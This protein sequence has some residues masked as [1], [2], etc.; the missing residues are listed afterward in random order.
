[1]TTPRRR[2]EQDPASTEVSEV[3][4]G[5]LRAQ[6]P[7][8]FTGLGHVNCYVLP[9]D[10]GATIVDP[11]MPGKSTMTALQARLDSI[12]IP[13]RRVHTVIVTHAHPDHYGGAGWVRQESGADIV[14]HQL[15]HTIIDRHDPPDLDVEDA[16]ALV[17]DG[18][19]HSR[20]SWW[21]PPPWGGKHPMPLSRRLL[22]AAAR[23]FPRFAKTPTPTRRITDG[24]TMQLAGRDW[25]VM[26][27]PGHTDDHVCFYDPTEGVLLSGDHVLPTITPHIGG[28]VRNADPLQSFFESLTKVAALGDQVHTVLPA[29]GHPFDDLAGRA[30]S[31]AE[32]H[33]G[34]L[35]VA[36][37]AIAGE[38]SATVGA[39]S[40]HLFSERAQGPMADSETYA[41]LEHLRRAGR[42]RRTEADDGFRYSLVAT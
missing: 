7:I 8:E 32:H 6:L 19:H 25:F 9:D 33:R 26:H 42:V 18:E 40:H 5:V 22:V 1:M 13:L 30:A 12:G 39:V 10:R 38:G 29:H 20:D 34:R 23:R 21:K 31:I 14:T 3:A 28:W 11:G 36:A 16:A 35:A 2:Q 27:T 4:P 24:T 15:F 41:H 37:E 17:V